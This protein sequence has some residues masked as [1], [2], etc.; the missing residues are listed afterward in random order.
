MVN[1]IRRWRVLT[2]WLVGITSL[3][4]YL[5]VDALKAAPGGT[6]PGLSVTGRYLIDPESRPSQD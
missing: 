2:G 3:F 5:E 1:R 4:W 6:F